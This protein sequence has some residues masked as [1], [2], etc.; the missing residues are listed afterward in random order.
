MQTAIA[1][2]EQV[3]KEAMEYDRTPYHPGGLLKGVGVDCG[4]L[5][6]CTYRD[7][8]LLTE[9]AIEIFSMDWF[10][11]TTEERYMN[12]L[13]RHAIRVAEAVSYPTLQALPGNMAL[14]KCA[15]SKVYNHGGIVIRWPKVI[16][17]VTPRVEII[18]AST[19]QMWAYRTVVIF[20]PWEKR[21]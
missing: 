18:D 7:C 6:Y 8:G 16:H 11:N 15:N 17:A 19:H 10:A 3:V 4:T 9:E 5:L 2:R 12:K 14:T 1:T 20:D 21:E 13:M